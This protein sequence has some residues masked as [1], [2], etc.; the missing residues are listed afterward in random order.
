MCVA[1]S[2]AA[3][4]MQDGEKQE[5][6]KRMQGGESKIPEGGVSSIMQVGVILFPQERLALFKKD[7]G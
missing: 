1:V 5:E 3:V 4:K 7:D 2:S 6:K